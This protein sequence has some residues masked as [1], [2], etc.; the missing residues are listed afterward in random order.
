MSNFIHYS[1]FDIKK[2]VIEHSLK[3]I[4]PKD[5]INFCILPY[6]DTTLNTVSTLDIKTD[7]ISSN[8]F[9]I[10]IVPKKFNKKMK[11]IENDIVKKYGIFEHY[12]LWSINF[13]P[14]DSIPPNYKG[15]EKSISY[16]LNKDRND[17]CLWFYINEKELHTPFCI[18]F[19]NH[20]G[21]EMEHIVQIN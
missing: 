8:K 7:R 17:V 3:D 10:R 19:V 5:V 18:K 9:L 2:N 20:F 14:P 15:I 6:I 11:D 1:D 4:L 16:L 12:Y 13:F 21:Y